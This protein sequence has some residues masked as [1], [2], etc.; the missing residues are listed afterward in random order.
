MTRDEAVE[1]LWLESEE[2][3]PGRITREGCEWVVDLFIEKGLL[4]TETEWAIWRAWDSKYFLQASEEAARGGS[5]QV[6]G[7]LTV[8]RLVGPWKTEPRE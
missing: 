3:F 4:P 6:E 8:S 1:L 2:Q 7:F 5:A